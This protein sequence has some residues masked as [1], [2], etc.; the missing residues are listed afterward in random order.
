MPEK[1]LQGLGGWLIFPIIGF[2][3]AIPVYFL[4]IFL[5]ISELIQSFFVLTLI[6]YIILICLF[7]VTL[8]FAFTKS[9]KAP[10]FFIITFWTQY[11]VLNILA[12]ILIGFSSSVIIG[13]SA[14]IIWTLYF[15][16]SKRVKNTFTK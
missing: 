5:R 6:L 1:K 8:V 15:I 10:L 7:I 14:P 16:K 13:L 4:Y 12:W 11:F 2:I 3:I 9:K